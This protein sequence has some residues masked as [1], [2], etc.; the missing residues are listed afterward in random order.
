[1]R[2][3]YI[4]EYAQVKEFVEEVAD[5]Y[6]EMTLNQAYWRYALFA[7]AVIAV[8]I[9]L[10]FAGERLA[11]IMGWHNTFV[12]TLF[13][14][15]ITSLPELAVTI[16]TFCMGALDM[17]IANLLGS[18]LFDILVLVLE[19]LIFLTGPLLSYIS[20]LHVFSAISAL[21]MNGI[22]IVGLVYRPSTRLFFSIGGSASACS[23]FICLM[24]MYF[25]CMATNRESRFLSMKFPLKKRQHK[26]PRYVNVFCNHFLQH[27][28]CNDCYQCR[29][30]CCD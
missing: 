17:A 29:R 24:S 13:V 27:S 14:A 21:I 20:P 18:D 16:A 1:M 11:A 15:A 22:V 10:P 19:D 30:Q 9:Y 23:R 8:G 28:K 25:I 3:L 7:I 12:G 6:L 26:R 2:S 4:H 5:R